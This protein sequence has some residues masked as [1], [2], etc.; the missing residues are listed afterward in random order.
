MIMNIQTLTLDGKE[1]V[2]L[3]RKDYEDMVDIAEAT[4]IKNR[5][6]SGEEELIPSEIVNA[7]I[8]GESPLRVWRKHRSLTARD[9]ANQTALSAAYI[10]EI[11]T[12]KKD[13]SISAMKKI[14]VVL[15]VDIDDLV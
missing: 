10:S 5:I 14:A 6:N 15:D 2:I 9:L 13:G 8:A 1:F 4:K 11:E 3:S 7:L 12:G